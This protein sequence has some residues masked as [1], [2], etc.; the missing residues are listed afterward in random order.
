MKKSWKLILLDA[1]IEHLVLLIS[2]EQHPFFQDA[3]W[4]CLEDALH[5]RK[6]LLHC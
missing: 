5:Y 6:K 2:L 3:F 4:D 1:M